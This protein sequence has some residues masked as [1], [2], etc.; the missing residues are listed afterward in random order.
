MKIDIHS[1]RY[2]RDWRE[3]SWDDDWVDWDDWR[4]LWEPRWYCNGNWFYGSRPEDCSNLYYETWDAT[5]KC[6]TAHGLTDERTV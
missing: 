1:F 2:G 3:M 6:F 4:S 5:G